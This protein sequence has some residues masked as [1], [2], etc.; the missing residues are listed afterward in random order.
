MI[1][2]TLKGKKAVIFGVANDKSIAWGITQ[3]LTK[4]GAVVALA[5]QER[6]Q[7]LIEP[8]LEQL[9]E[10]SFSMPCD[11]QDDSLLDAFFERVKE[12][13]GTFDI[14]V[15]AVAFAK[16]EDLAGKFY[17]VNRRNYALAQDVSAYSLAALSQRAVPLMNKEGS[18]I[19]MTYMGSERVLP[20]YNV[21]GVCKAAL[22]ASIRYLAC[23]VGEK[24][25]R[26]N[27]ISAGPVKT[28]A[29]SGIAGF[30]EILKV[31]EQKS[32]SSHD[33]YFYGTRL[34]I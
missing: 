21:M 30:D 33:A 34:S 19:A 10:G 24:G 29:A 7:Q 17:N 16:K 32:Q 5:Y 4:A 15:H 11:V 9:P 18:I 14:L 25:I 2:I 12:K 26:V 8:L 23:D 28:L 20:N 22:E 27:G 6:I 3:A 13:F 31:Y 1:N